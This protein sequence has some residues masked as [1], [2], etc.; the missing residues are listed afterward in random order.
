MLRLPLA[1]LN[2]LWTHVPPDLIA[3]AAR[4]VLAAVFRASDR[5]AV[6]DQGLKP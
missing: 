4:V 2:A 1:R 6:D 5:T 3:L